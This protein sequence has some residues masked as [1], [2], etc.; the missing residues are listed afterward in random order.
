MSAEPWEA[1][2]DAH[3][4]LTYAPLQPHDRSRREAIAAARLAGLS[5]GSRVLDVPCGYGRHAVP[6]AVEGYVVVGLDWSA[7]Q[8][9]EARR[10]RGP[11][12]HT[13]FR[14]AGPPRL[15]PSAGEPIR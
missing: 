11:V 7:T 4:V 8:L 1:F 12:T 5:P 14:P 2:F 6:L 10:R 13:I 15:A 9:A 3:Y